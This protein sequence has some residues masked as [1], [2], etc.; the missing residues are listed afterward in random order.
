LTNGSG[1]FTFAAVPP[2]TYRVTIT[3]NGFTPWVGTDISL[4]LGQ[5]QVLQNVTLRIGSQTTSVQV[6][7]S[8]AAVI[9]LD[10]GAS[11]N[12]DQQ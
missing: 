3:A 4:H 10:T 5:D 11:S 1:F 12:H 2:A 6:V 9:P 7:S 8:Q